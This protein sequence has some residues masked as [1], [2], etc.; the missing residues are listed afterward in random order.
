MPPLVSVLI[1]CHNAAP[2]LHD[3]LA[4]VLDQTWQ[5]LEVIV[6]DDGSTDD[7]IAVA[8]RSESDRRVRVISQP[9]AGQSASEN[10]AVRESRGE[11]LEFLDADDLLAP[12]KIE[13]QVAVLEQA[14]PDYV[15]SAEWARFYR[16]PSDGIFETQPL[17]E[18]LE[19][20]EWLVRAWSGHLMMHGAAWLVPRGVAERAGL[21]DERLSLINDFDYFGRVVL[22]SRGVKFC[23]G[24]RTYYRS[25]NQGSLSGT[26]SR[27]AWESALL[28]LQ[29]GTS[30]LLAA[31]TSPR[32]LTVCAA[33]FQRYAY[34]VFA[35]QPDLADIAAAR[36]AELG[37]SSEQPLGG[38]L[39]QWLSHAVGWRR[40][41]RVRQKAYELG[42]QRAA[43]GWRVSRAIR[44]WRHRGDTPHPAGSR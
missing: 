12:D 24:A 19:P 28:A 23:R 31:E 3:T 9:N 13:R 10:R 27:R 43:V 32:T 18:D 35:Q 30:N 4:S 6:I 1:P 41:S 22:A 5:N 33:V 7:T 16:S 34:E 17:W 37:G 14:G 20:I 29:L 21:W 8:R 40:A 38:P 42:Y 25:G 39:F 44:Q 36:A 26:K 15:A 2:W 11:Y